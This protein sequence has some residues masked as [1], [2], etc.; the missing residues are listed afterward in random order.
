MD[1]I[2]EHILASFKHPRGARPFLHL[3]ENLC[4]KACPTLK[5]LCQ[6]EVKNGVCTASTIRRIIAIHKNKVRLKRLKSN[7]KVK[8]RLKTWM[9][10]L[11]KKKERK[12]MSH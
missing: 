2:C 5:K 10:V 3:I 4:L 6:V 8:Q 7:K 9:T 11:K 12:I 1:I